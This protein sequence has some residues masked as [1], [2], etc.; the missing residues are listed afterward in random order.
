MNLNNY[1]R[2]SRKMIVLGNDGVGKTSL[3]AGIM[4]ETYEEMEGRRGIQLVG[5]R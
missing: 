5:S 4:G 2:N 3:I 1:M